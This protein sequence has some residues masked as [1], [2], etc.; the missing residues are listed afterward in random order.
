MLVRDFL[1]DR[2]QAKMKFSEEIKMK[3]SEL[4]EQ[5]CGIMPTSLSCDWDRDGLEVCPEDREVG[6]VLI[7]LDCTDE[8]IQKAADGGFDVILTHHPLFFGG[9][10]GV[11]VLD[12]CGARAVRLVRE[13]ISVMSFHTRLDAVSGGVNDILA[14]KLGLEDASAVGAEGIMRIGELRDGMDADAF[15]RLVK[16]SLCAPC[17]TL[18]QCGKEVKRVAV[19]GGSG[20]DDISLARSLGADT[21][22]TGELKYHQLLSAGDV[23][24]NLLCAGH[25]YTE[26]PVT[27]HL[28]KLVGQICED[29]YT[30]IF[31]SDRIEVI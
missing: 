16:F 21:Y 17:V 13:G 2:A 6:K 31:F 12:P 18:T 14:S 30:E 4:Y 11:S 23:G 15:A 27:E 10:G 25:F 5:L 3:V 8:V 1:F 7:A 29:I 28:Q 26:Y 19:L 22:L 24:M 20:G 9:L